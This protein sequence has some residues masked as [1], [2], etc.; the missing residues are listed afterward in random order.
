MLSLLDERP[1]FLCDLPFLLLQDRARIGAGAG[2]SQLE[3]LPE[4]VLLPFDDCQEAR[5]SVGELGVDRAEAEQGPAQQKGGPGG[6]GADRQPSRGDSEG[7]VVTEGER[8]PDPDGRERLEGGGGREQERRGVA[9]RS[10]R[11][12]ESRQHD[13]AG[14]DEI[15]DRRQRHSPECRGLGRAQK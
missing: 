9:K 3:I 11:E 6:D 13:A 2:E 14:E 15:R 12:C 8:D 10:S 7:P 4:P 5:L 1:P